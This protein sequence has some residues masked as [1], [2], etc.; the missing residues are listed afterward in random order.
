MSFLDQSLL[1]INLRRLAQLKMEVINLFNI[2]YN[3]FI[4]APDSSIKRGESPGCG[5]N[6]FIKSSNL[7]TTSNLP[8]QLFLF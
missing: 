8:F 5:L 7:F 3:L 2:I 1:P 6:L 4:A